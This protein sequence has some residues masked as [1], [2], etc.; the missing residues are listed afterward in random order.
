[1]SL[2][3]NYEAPNFTAQ[4]TRGTIDFHHLKDGA[5]TILTPF[6]STKCAASFGRG[7]MLEMSTRSGTEIA[8]SDLA[9]NP[10]IPCLIRHMGEISKGVD[11]AQL[12][13]FPFVTAPNWY[14]GYWC[15]GDELPQVPARS[16]P[17]RR[18]AA[19]RN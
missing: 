19:R 8:S 9:N 5:P 1:M 14:A 17:D 7:A 18:S 10:G 16:R 13:F 2:R 6:P 11:E 15:R 12:C 3:I 4:T